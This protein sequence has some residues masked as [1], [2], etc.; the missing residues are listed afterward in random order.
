MTDGT[1]DTTDTSPPEHASPEADFAAQSEAPTRN[2]VVE[3][4]ADFVQFLREEKKWWLI[5]IIVSLGL[6]ALVALLLNSPAAP[7]IYPAF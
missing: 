7:F 3:L 6:I 1:S 2:V 5:P 4:A